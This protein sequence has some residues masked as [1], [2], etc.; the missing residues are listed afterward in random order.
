M[1]LN[2][3]FFNFEAGE[4]ILI[5]KPKGITSFDV[6]RKLKR[7]LPIRKIGHAGTLDPMATG[8]LILCTGKKTKQISLYQDQKKV[9][10]G[11]ITL[12]AET[13]SYDAETQPQNYQSY[14]HITAED[15][16]TAARKFTGH[17][18]QMPPVYSALKVNGERAYNK[19][20]KGEKVELQPRQV[21]VRKFEITKVNLPEV[22]FLIE[23]SKGTYI[24]SLAHDIGLELGT[25]AY[26]TALRREAIGDFTIEQAATIEEFVEAA[27]ENS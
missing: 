11:T 24:R 27:K 12:G 23:C 8:V 5:D 13:P 25:G 3:Q 15:I 19:A 2:K 10:S 20:R 21:H 22:N 7:Q 9:Y 4:I 26:L 16:E 6:I 17:I 18:Q 14:H 1:D